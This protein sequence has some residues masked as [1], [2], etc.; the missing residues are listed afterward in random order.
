MKDREA[1]RA[2]V[3]G[4]PKSWTRLRDKTATRA[5]ISQTEG[6]IQDKEN[7]LGRKIKMILKVGIE[8]P[9]NNM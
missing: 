2:A 6:S 3:H 5:N 4:V 1:W 9:L 8:F 7:N